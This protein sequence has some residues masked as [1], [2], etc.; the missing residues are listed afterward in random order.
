[1]SAFRALLACSLFFF[2]AI[3][4]ASAADSSLRTF[5]MGG[6]S[7]DVTLPEG[8]LDVSPDDVLEWARRAAE[9]VTTYYGHFPTKHLTLKISADDREGVHY[10]TT[11]PEGG[12]LIVISVGR[13]TSKSDLATDWMLTHEMIHLAFPSMP[14]R[15]HWIEEG[16]SVYVE[17]VARVQ[18]GQLAV[19]EMW[20]ET[21][22]DMHQ[23]EPQPGDEGL[24]QTHTWGRTYWGGAMFGL[25]ADVRI[26][27]QTHNQ[28][29]LR[30]ALRAILDHGG[31][32][33]QDWEIPR[34][35][36][37][38]DEATGTNVLVDLYREMRD[39]PD[40]IDLAELWKKLGIRMQGK[41]VQFDDI[42]PDAALRQ[43]I[44][45]KSSQ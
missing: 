43:A 45:Q 44:T 34:A 26:R 7:I 40:A 28:E 27:E 36:Q 35:L 29:G 14:R 21:L 23:G 13:H 39:Q 10:G 2:F 15:Q 38:G 18:A 17:P 22:R 31:V 12:G 11:Y 6:G 3:S 8:P 37:I 33:T 32:I 25:V 9:A 42:A 1:M 30:N 41:M 16:I 4:F 19:E 24:D 5:V 20:Y